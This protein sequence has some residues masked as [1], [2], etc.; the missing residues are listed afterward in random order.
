MKRIKMIKARFFLSC[1]TL[2]LFLVMGCA[3]GG[4]TIDKNQSWEIVKKEVLAE[5]LQNK[6][7]Y[8]STEPLKAGQ[9][10]KSWKHIYKVPNNLQE[11][12]L[13]FVDD[14]PGANWE[15]ACRYIFVDTATGK[16]KVIKASTP[17]DSMENMKK[18]FS[19]TR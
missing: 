19:D 16:Y 8:I 3:S 18:I 9:A 1:L 17:P 15:H 5:S 12:W 4:K 13:F 6:I 11:A 14:Q 10:V 2:V 7:V